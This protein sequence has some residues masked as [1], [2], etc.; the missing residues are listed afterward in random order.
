MSIRNP[1]AWG[2]WKITRLYYDAV[3]DIPTSL[4]D[5]DRKYMASTGYN[6]LGLAARAAGVSPEAA[7]QKARGCIAAVVPV[8]SGQG[9]IPGFSSA[10]KS[11]LNHIG[12]TG[13]VT[14][15]TDIAGIGEAF[16]RKAHLLFLADDMK[17][18]AINLQNQNVVENSRATALGFVHALA[19][20]T[21]LHSKSVAGAKVLVMGLG[22]VGT[23]AAL[24]LERIGFVVSV[25]DI[26]YIK[27]ECFVGLHPGIEAV[28]DPRRVSRGIT[29]IYDATPAPEIIDDDMVQPLTVTACPGVP[30]GLTAGALAKSGPRFIHDVLPLGVCVMA[31]Q[32]LF[33]PGD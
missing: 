9:L 33:R 3:K 27:A 12:L 14:N 31:L 11:I 20:A 22:P 17:F 2:V 4:D 32:A 15:E 25:F 16:H 19:A 10:V 1:W 18:L 26:D 5:L 28:H 30:H 23:C 8:T 29:H 13:I 7:K 6:L 24:E 21:E